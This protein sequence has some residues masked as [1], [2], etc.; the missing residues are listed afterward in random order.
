[1]GLLFINACYREGSRT[2]K[3]AEYFV[4]R[5]KGDV[6]EICIGEPEVCILDRKRLEIYNKA[7]A[8]RIFTDPMFHYAKKFREAEEILIAAPFWNNSIPAALH[9]YLE[10][11]CTQGITFDIR[12]NGQYFSMCRGKK[13]T[14]ITTAGGFIPEQ[15]H[16]FGY[17]KSLAETF[18]N[19][20]DVKYYKAEGLDI[21][22]T[23]ADEILSRVLK[24]FD[25]K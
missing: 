13:L 19:I 23:D 22:G 15:D 21:A 2:G 24:T 18:W 14:Y 20:R 12:E 9:A 16:G 25:T 7:V 11:V 5:Y 3:L 8:E 17:I 6:E 10:L 4:N 1:M